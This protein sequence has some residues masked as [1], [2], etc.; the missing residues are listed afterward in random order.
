MPEEMQFTLGVETGR[1]G[2]ER[3]ALFFRTRTELWCVFSDPLGICFRK[4]LDVGREDHSADEMKRDHLGIYRILSKKWNEL[5]AF[6]K[7]PPSAV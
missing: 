3:P 2:R 4:K 6:L 5:S 7:K 1:D